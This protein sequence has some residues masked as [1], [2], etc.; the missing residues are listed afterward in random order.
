MGKNPDSVKSIFCGVLEKNNAREQSAYLDSACHSD[1]GLRAEVESLLRSHKEAANFLPSPGLNPEV[2]TTK[3]LSLP[4]TYS[5]QVWELFDRVSDLAPGDQEALLD[6]EC[7]ND[8]ELH[9]NVE[10]LLRCRIEAPVALL[11]RDAAANNWLRPGSRLEGYEIVRLIGTGGMGKV[12]EAQQ[13]SPRRCVALKVI[14]PGQMSSEARGRFR[15]EGEILGQLQ[16]LGIAQIFEAGTATLDDGTELPFIAMEY[17]SGMRLDEYVRREGLGTYARLELV[18]RVCDAVHHAHQRGVIHRD[19]K[20][21]NVLVMKDGTAGV[22]LDHRVGRVGQPKVLDFGIARVIGPEA[23]RRTIETRAD[24]LLGTLAYMSP[25]QVSGNTAYIDVRSDVWALGVML[26]EVLAGCH[27]ID[28]K[29]CSVPEAVRRI[30][31]TDPA[32]LTDFDSTLRG[33]V[34]ILVARALAKDK[35]RRYQTAADLAEDI[36]RYLRGEVIEARADSTFY[37]LRKTLRRHRALA[38]GLAAVF[39][40]F[41]AGVVGIAA[42]AV[43]AD[44]QARTAQAVTDFL[45][46]DLLGSVALQQAMSQEVTVRSIVHA[47]SARLEGEFANKPLVEASIRQHLGRTY[48]ELGDYRQAELHLERAYD[49][50][51]SQL[52]DNDL[53]VLDSMSQFGRLRLL[54]GRYAE[55]EPLLARALESRRHRLGPDHIDTLRTSIWLGLVYRNLHQPDA[56][57]KAEALLTSAFESCNRFF[58]KQHP[59]TLEAMYGLAFLHLGGPGQEDKALPLC[60]EGWEIARKVLGEGHKLTFDFMVMGAWLQA[61]TGRFE[62]AER[63]AQI[64]IETGKRVLG[65][66]HPQ[67]IMAMGTLGQ[68]YAMQYLFDKAELPVAQAVQLGSKT[69]GKGNAWILQHMSLLGRVY[70]MQGKYQEAERQFMDVRANGADSFRIVRDA[71]IQII[72]LYIMQE[73]G[74]ALEHWCLEELN[75]LAQSNDGNRSLRASILNTVAWYQ[76]TYPSAAIRDGGK[77]IENA[78]KACELTDRDVPNHIDTLAVAYAEAGDFAAAV[79]EERVAVELAASRE[80]APL[81][82]RYLEF[83]LRLFESG[84]V[85]R[86]GLFSCRARSMLRD[87]KYQATEHELTAALAAARRFL[88]P[89]HPEIRGCI[90][91]FIELYEAWNR[92]DEAAKWRAQLAAVN[93]M[94]DERQ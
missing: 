29:D 47:A 11:R 28:L 15:H 86:E 21:E 51:H 62:E 42:F 79:R 94:N 85:I 34:S 61:W 67:T 5:D 48:V 7:A 1:A 72:S 58:G 68:V 3:I 65:E 93:K 12:Y 9:R 18:A 25:E 27:P 91:G 70:M 19:L 75:R 8:P 54:Q 17:V 74:E 50:R 53:L 46:K 44:R 38:T 14:Q 76:A 39:L 56:L 89:A 32:R 4:R 66:A 82:D 40:V 55:A 60:F 10:E 33:D 87:T 2:F 23:E 45:G 90:L 6:R 71:I 57:Q 16:H 30:K 31:E 49:L 81:S 41:L 69:L 52:G 24:S 63:N 13:F 20:P 77:A 84:Q 64:G 78:R 35:E 22:G 73:R 43:K 26:F 80:D 83:H 92:P 59:M 37:V 88:G 36:R